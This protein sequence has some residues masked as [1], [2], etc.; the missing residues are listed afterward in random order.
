MIRLTV[1]YNL[2]PHV[3]EEEF[4]RWRLTE[5]QAQNAGMPGVLRTDFGLVGE[6]W[7]P[8]TPPAYRFMTIADW[9]DMES[10]RQAFYEESMQATLFKDREAMLAESVFLVSEI[11][12]SDSNE[13]A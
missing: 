5:H 4:L 11:L 12:S 2:K 9:S 1:L 6:A 3:N 10:F 8:G 7:P 13:A